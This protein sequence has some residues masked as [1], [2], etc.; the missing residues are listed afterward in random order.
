M[1]LVFLDESGSAYSSYKTFRTGYESRFEAARR[2]Q[3]RFPRYPWFIVAAV[4]IPESKYSLVDEWFGSLK[5]NFL[6]APPDNWSPEYEI[7]GAMLYGLLQGRPAKDFTKDNEVVRRRLWSSLTI[8]Q[9]QALE[10]ALFGLLPRLQPEIWGVAIRQ[11]DVYRRFKTKTFS[12]HYWA[13]TYIQQRVAQSIQA[14]HGTY[15][16]ALLLMDETSSLNT[17]KTF[18]GFLTTRET[19]NTS[20]SF[21][22]TFRNHLIEVPMWGVS[23]LIPPLQLADVI[24]HAIHRR[25]RREDPRK[26]FSRIE[27]CLARHWS[28]GTIES[29]GLTIIK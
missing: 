24:A 4:S 20:A 29:A 25:M 17:S 28:S 6:K 14:R 2:G 27:G 9:L 26:W 15:E 7:K 18:H 21:P 13:L 11:A 22:I 23:H 19:I 10:E 16:R 3:G 12:P 5:H 1:E 8:R